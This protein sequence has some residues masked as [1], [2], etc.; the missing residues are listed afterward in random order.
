MAT[1]SHQE[2]I[3]FAGLMPKVAELLLGQP[4]A[5]L[6]RGQRLR[7]GSKGSMEID[8]GE[9]WFDDHE[10]NV[11][12]GV[13]ELIRHR[14]GCDKAGA[15]RWLEAKGL[16]EATRF[17][18]RGTGNRTN[19]PDRRLQPQR[20]FYDYCDEDG[21]TLFRVE[22]RGKDAVPPFLQHGPDGNGGFHAARGCMQGV[23]R[24]LYRLPE[25][26]AA[27]PNAIVF[28]CEGEKDANR[29]ADAG[30]IATT[31]PGGAGKFIADFAP[32]LTGRRVI[33]LQDNDEAGA[34]HVAAVLDV[35]RA[36]AASAASLLLPGLPPKGD[37]SD[38]L[39][40]GGSAFELKRLAE[41]MLHKPVDTFAIADL[42]AWAQ[43]EPEPKS[44]RMA[45]IIPECEV[46]LFTGPGGTNKSTFG[47]Q[48]CAASAAGKSMLGIA[49]QPGPALYVTAE[50]DD[51]E[52]HWRLRKIAHAIGTTLDGLARKLSV[53][54]LRGRLNN[55]LATFD[56][57][58]KLRPA[59]AFALL[60]ATIEQTGAKLI[61][62]DNVGHLYIGN[63]ND[64]GQVTGFI[65]LL[66]QLCRE[67]GVTIVLIGH[68]NKAGDSY[69][70][71]T[72]WLNA[73]RSQI[74]LQRPED[75]FDP[76]ARVLTLGKA[77]YARPDQQLAFRWHD[78]ALILE[79]DLPDDRRTEIT[80]IIRTNSDNATF[81]ACLAARMGQG[82]GRQ[83]GP[84]TGP[85]YAP[86]QFEGMPQAKGLKRDR[87]KAAMDRLFTIEAIETHTYRNTVK[88]RDVTI[89][90]AVSPN[91]EL[92]ARTLPEHVPQT[93]PNSTPEHTT[94][95][96][97]LL[98]RGMG[99][100]FRGSA[101][102]P[103]R[104]DESNPR[105][106]RLAPGETGNEPIPGWEDFG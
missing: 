1:A 72:A 104:P 49:V 56:A 92:V 99:A 87:L 32:A 82:E 73:V 91:P 66:Y 96:T 17:A 54:S 7:F 79:T 61:V 60:R 102:I 40:N 80:D 28:V 26:L 67:L 27:D 6:S 14:E 19:G 53:V 11:K 77:N 18:P 71:S 35:V 90:R 10:A 33:V 68:P 41:K 93:P 98:R 81:M 23:R 3:D 30:L 22:R 100:A 43:H 42:S 51:R 38:W 34:N 78:F 13:L 46:T 103:E 9:G 25:L 63:E 95:H 59:P 52:N 64:R 89:I 57:E 88:G 47:L 48:L 45:G 97:P 44:F 62:L 12:G 55:E 8:T 5:R 65:N 29:L 15:F 2:P 106:E 37:V 69:S 75:G 70:G 105:R 94:P 74:V 16:K 24:V 86:T 83:V 4:N 58:G 31:N 85:N 84:H 101:P 76:D 21:A 39:A 50:D 36:T 20:A